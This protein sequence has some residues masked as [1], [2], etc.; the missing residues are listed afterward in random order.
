[1]SSSYRLNFQVSGFICFGLVPDCAGCCVQL[2]SFFPLFARH[3]SRFIVTIL[4]LW[5]SSHYSYFFSIQEEMTYSNSIAVPTSWNVLNGRSCEH[6]LLAHRSSHLGF[7]NWVTLGTELHAF[8]RITY[9]ISGVYLD[10][11]PVFFN[12]DS[13]RCPQQSVASW[14]ETLCLQ[15]AW[16]C[17][18][19][20]SCQ[21]QGTAGEVPK[22]AT[23]KGE[24]LVVMPH[25]TKATI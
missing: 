13:P 9:M 1:M 24:V 18:K 6:S 16:K 15:M 17:A 3:T 21:S 4:S 14:S 25:W 10:R 2:S 12:R 7:R 5:V 19:V 23:A 22:A 11:Q 20:L 8:A